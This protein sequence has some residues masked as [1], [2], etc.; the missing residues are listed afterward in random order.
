MTGTQSILLMVITLVAILIF[1]YL[2]YSCLPDKKEEK[3]E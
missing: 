3:E 2:Y 1:G